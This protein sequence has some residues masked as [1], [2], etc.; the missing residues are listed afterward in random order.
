MRCKILIF[1]A[2]L[3]LTAGFGVSVAGAQ[4]W[5]VDFQG[6]ENH[7]STYGQN[8]P[9]DYTEP[10]VYWNMFEVT[11]FSAV[12]ATD[13]STPPTSM[14]LLDTE[15]ND[16]GVTLTILTDAWGW[17]NEGTLDDLWGDYLIILNAQGATSDP[18]D[19]EITGLSP[20]TLCE[21]TYYHRANISGR[22]LNFVAN[23]VETTVISTIDGYMAT[24][25]VMTDASG[26]ITGTADSDGYSEGC[27]AG[28]VIAI[29]P[30][31][32][33]P[34]PADGAIYPDTWA[35]LGWTPGAFAGSHDVYF[36][37]SFD[38]V[39]SGAEA[40]FRGNQASTFFVVGFPGFPYPDGLVPGTT[41]YWR[42]DGVDDLHP[43]SPW[44][45]DVWSFIV[46]PKTAYNPNPADG[47]KFIDPE[48]V[49]SWT[50]GFGAKL[51]TVYFGENFDDVNNAAGGLPQGTMTYTLAPLELGKSYYWRVDEFDA[52]TT[53]KG[54]VWSFRT[55]PVIPIS[56]P[57]L[58]GWWK[59]DEGS[60]NI[61]LDWSGHDNHGELRGGPQWVSGYDGI[62]LEF[63]GSDDYVNFSNTS[64]WASGTSARSMCGWGKTDT[65]AGGWR[66][67][68]AYGSPGT[69]QAM[70][71][72][73]NGADLY[74]GGYGDDVF[75]SNFLEV[76][77]WHHICLTYDGT[78]ARLYADGINVATE[79]KDWNLA[80]GRA[81]IG[82]QVNDLAEFWDGAIDDV[83]IYNK[84]LTKDEILQAMRGDTTLAWN[85]SP[86]NESV[87]NLRDAGSLSWSAGE[88]ASQHDVY[89]GTDENVVDNADAS[90]TTGVYSGRQAATSYT[91]PEGVE[92]G[93]GP[94]YWRIDE[95]NTDG[96]IVKGRVWGFSVA[97]YITVDDFES[98]NDLNEDEPGSNR[99]FNAWLDGFDNPSMNGSIVG[100]GNPPFTE[101]TIVNSGKQS[102]PF[103]YDNGVGKSE[104]TL[105]LTYPR[106]WTEDGVGILSLWFY[107]DASNDA[108]PM[109][110]VL[111]GS[112]VV[113]NDNP[114]AAQTASWTEWTIELQA[115][116]VNLTNVNTITLGFGNR[117]NPVAG[118]SGMVFFDDIRL[119]RPAP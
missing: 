1:L 44:T 87:P 102:M 34:Q 2:A 56:D 113:T 69:S 23:G 64:G 90:D 17:A 11:G 57:N 98:Y 51:H 27:W 24:A 96:T 66:W 91:P 62:A 60:G 54:D 89:F 33:N 82:Q 101:H 78:T 71:I 19:W 79:S 100:Y 31:A 38:D 107:G 39:N 55:Q 117:S 75:Q 88:N 16:H 85:P 18:T 9:R 74:G 106:D 73:I 110:V 81:H 65:I 28:L 116:G 83:R 104:A 40:A 26:K 77:V 50:A 45:G 63:D 41:Y 70:F 93:G 72:G 114:N 118:G 95:V 67:I 30:T 49:F 36:G 105:T 109:Y 15:S 12:G 10:G 14:N 46:P 47:A 37:E 53:Y 35:S 103:F 112:A 4:T 29:I 32:R 94:Y 108:E 80:L 97:D 48:I 42:V 6:D 25:S 22:G 99:I 115:F 59:L 3:V 92:W 8:G 68:A 20:D 119:Y 84:A 43:D 7:N 86:A 58:V 52:V 5:K 21:L 13:V 76:G 111:N 61:A